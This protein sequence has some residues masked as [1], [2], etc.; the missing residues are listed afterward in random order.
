[1]RASLTALAVL[2]L[3]AGCARP[4]PSDYLGGAV[5]RGVEAIGVGQNASGE[6]CSQLPGDARDTVAVFCGTW[7]QPA[8]RIHAGDAAGTATPMTVAASGPWRDTINLRFICDAPVATSSS[9][10]SSD[11]A[12]LNTPPRSGRR[13]RLSS[14][15]RLSRL[16]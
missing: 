9:T 12:T 10:D 1:M 7:Q 6:T 3:L 4:Q 16:T 11:P 8:A 2:S 5:G 14:Q 15:A 13:W